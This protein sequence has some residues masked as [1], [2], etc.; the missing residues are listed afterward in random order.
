METLKK[1]TEQDNTAESSSPN[2]TT[3]NAKMGKIAKFFHD[4]KTAKA[5]KAEKERKDEEAQRRREMY[6]V[7]DIERAYVMAEAEENYRQKQRAA[8]RQPLDLML[9]AVSFE[10][11]EKY[12]SG[13]LNRAIQKSTNQLYDL[14]KVHEQ[15]QMPDRIKGSLQYSLMRAEEKYTENMR[16]LDRRHYRGE[17][18]EGLAREAKEK[19]QEEL[20]EIRSS[21]GIRIKEAEEKYQRMKSEY[22][23]KYHEPFERS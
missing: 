2:E 16:D 23:A 5:E 8:G 21:Y 9:D 19:Y 20:K 17:E 11:S 12:K 22:E 14:L 4:R 18:V 6:G 15:R 10:A 1:H 7:E 13:E 3:R